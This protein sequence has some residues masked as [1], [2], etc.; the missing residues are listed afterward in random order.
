[1]L[2]AEQVTGMVGPETPDCDCDGCRML[3]RMKQAIVAPVT[4]L[5]DTENGV[6]AWAAALVVV[7][8]RLSAQGFALPTILDALAHGL[9]QGR[10]QNPLMG[11]AVVPQSH[12]MH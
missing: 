12:C 10:E 4:A 11:D 2:T 8:S 9:N 5:D 6:S 3:L 7:G 1:M